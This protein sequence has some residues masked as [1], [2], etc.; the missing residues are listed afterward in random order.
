MT[1]ILHGLE[2]VLELLGVA[3]AELQI[4]HRGRARSRSGQGHAPPE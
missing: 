3:I 2:G 4:R 1:S